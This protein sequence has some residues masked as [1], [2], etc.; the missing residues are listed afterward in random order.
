MWSAGACAI[1][2]TIAF[3]LE[4]EGFNREGHPSLLSLVLFYFGLALVSGSLLGA[5]QPI[6]KGVTGKAFVG[7]MTAWPA[8]YG[9]VAWSQDWRL[10][11]ITTVDHAIAFGLALVAGPLGAAYVH[12]RGHAKHFPK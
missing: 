8:S 12:R 6:A 3:L 11:E 4:P 10:S 1:V 7:F 5:L 2:A 9:I